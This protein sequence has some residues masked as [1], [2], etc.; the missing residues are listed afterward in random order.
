MTKFVDDRVEQLAIDVPVVSPATSCEEVYRLFQDDPDLLAIAVLENGKPVGLVH[1]TDMMLALA[2]RFGFALYGRRPIHLLANDSPLIVD[3]SNSIDFL[4]NMLAYD[5]PHALLKGF[6]ICRGR[7]YL[8]VGT[9]ISLL[10]ASVER[11]K[12]R[13]EELQ[14][15]KTVAIEANKSKS[16]FLANMNHELRTPLNAIIGFTEMMQR[17]IYGRVPQQEYRE[18]IDIVHNSGTHLLGVINA[19]LDMSKIEAG[20]MELHETD[21]DIYEL[22]VQVRR[23]LISAAQHKNIN[24]VLNL[25]DGLPCLWG[26]PTMI[27]QILLNLVNNAIKFSPDFT[28]VTLKI[29]L[30]PSGDLQIVVSDQG[31]GISEAHQEAVLRPFFQVESDLNRSQEG[32]GLGLSIVKA[33]LEL[34]NARLTIDSAPGDGT[35][36]IIVFPHERLRLYSAA[37]TYYPPPRLANMG[38]GA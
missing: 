28:T 1:R 33:Y 25:Q 23:M 38:A 4:S 2:D 3:A 7:E 26:D 14:K 37:E 6:I 19:I 18:Y 31:I 22:V 13:A 8:G 20:Q 24:I 34:H 17:E 10:Q 15:A 11:S 29:Q 35:D 16:A 5:A 9:A 36:M 30:L 21:C 32:S 27:R 12:K